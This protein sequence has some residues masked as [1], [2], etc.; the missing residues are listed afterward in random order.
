MHQPSIIPELFLFP[1]TAELLIY[2]WLKPPELR[3]HEA[4]SVQNLQRGI[5]T[6]RCIKYLQPS[7]KSGTDG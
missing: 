5:Y 6:T 4:T 2:L 1:S 7:D 3:P